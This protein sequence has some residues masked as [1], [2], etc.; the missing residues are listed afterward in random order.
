MVL[1][2]NLT[3]RA[4]GITIRN[5]SSFIAVNR[6]CSWISLIL[7]FPTTFVNFVLIIAFA[8]SGE[9][10]KLCTLFLMNL[11]ITD[12]CSGV[13]NMPGNFLTFRYI[14]NGKDPCRFA[15][16]Y[17]PIAFSLG[18]TS[19]FT[20]TFIAIDRYISIF[21]PFYY[22]SDLSWKKVA[23]CIILSW[24]V[25]IAMIIP[26]ALNWRSKYINGCIAAV[27]IS[28]IVVN[29]YCYLRI[30]LKARNIRRQIK[31][32]AQRFGECSIN[33]T[34]KRFIL[35]GAVILI[36]MLICCAPFGSLNFVRG[37]TQSSKVLDHMRC[38]EWVLVTANSLINPLI[39]C[40]FVP[41]IRSKIS[42]ILR[43]R[44]ELP[45]N[46]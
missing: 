31:A 46:S 33:Q 11:A 32:E 5:T 34:E 35:V 36:S 42:K 43:C 45:A 3:C 26:A 22:S 37:I 25:P 16:I 44:R 30:F 10:K 27:I 18:G 13:L 29:S 4:Y 19:L 6:S 38:L 9:R 39:T 14:A 20:V 40:I 41:P 7:A 28:G 23:I 2:M 24:I 21:H 12:L 17:L 8:T 15:S 1:K